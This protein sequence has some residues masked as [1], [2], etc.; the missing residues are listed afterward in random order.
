MKLRDTR[1]NKIKV[2]KK[3]KEK[4]SSIIEKDRSR[5]E[6]KGDLKEENI[7]FGHAWEIHMI[8]GSYKE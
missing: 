5:E 4:W 3:K 6:S 8:E 1:A 2:K 7:T